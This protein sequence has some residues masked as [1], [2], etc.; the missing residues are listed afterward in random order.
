M[1]LI[2]SEGRDISTHRVIDWLLYYDVKYAVIN[3]EE[4]IDSIV[5]GI[6]EG[7]S[8]NI[9]VKNKVLFFKDLKAVWYRRGTFV[10]ELPDL[11]LVKKMPDVVEK[12]LTSEWSSVVE[13][14]HFRLEQ[15]PSLGSY[16]NNKH[17][18]KLTSILNAEKCGL[19]IPNTWIVDNKRDLQNI[20][21]KHPK[22]I[23]KS[24]LNDLKA[25]DG[26]SIEFGTFGP[27]LITIDHIKDIDDNFFPSLV[28]EY[29]EKS[30]ELRIFTVEQKLW[31]MAIFSQLDE[32]TSLDFRNYNWSNPN[33]MVSYI[34]PEKYETSI[35]NF[36]KIS[37]ITTGSIDMV[38]TPNGD[39]VFLEINPV[40]QFDFVS[41]NC[42]YFIEKEI[43][44]HLLALC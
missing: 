20:L 2:I 11:R 25:R 41:Q 39:Y 10:K 3:K 1:V 4:K 18:N 17:C 44:E 23:T 42:N 14:L 38:V 12:H 31:C 7:F 29:V 8:F 28:Q 32:Q 16:F 22:L 40:G 36:L 35:R 27:T 30:Y 21:S 6:G 43:A 15:L 9:V 26:F 24:I 5:I 19:S 34:L 37:G 33:R 13:M